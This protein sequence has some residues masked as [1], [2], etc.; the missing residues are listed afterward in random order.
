M[1]VIDEGVE[2]SR[3]HQQLKFLRS[4]YAQGF[5]FARPPPAEAAEALITENPQ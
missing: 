4:E 5:C 2:T 1:S 3:Q